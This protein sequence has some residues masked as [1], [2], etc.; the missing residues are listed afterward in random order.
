MFK[1]GLLPELDDELAEGVELALAVASEVGEGTGGAAPEGAAKTMP[2]MVRAAPVGPAAR[3][4]VA[5]STESDCET[6]RM[7]SCILS[8]LVGSAEAVAEVGEGRRA[9]DRGFSMSRSGISSNGSDRFEKGMCKLLRRDASPLKVIS[10]FSVAHDRFWY[11][12]SE[13]RLCELKGTLK[14]VCAPC[15]NLGTPEA[16]VASLKVMVG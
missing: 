5:V 13:S 4:E 10:A 12:N 6:S 3:A 1:I 11:A 15:S 7:A 14:F 16:M 2:L 8:W 9:C